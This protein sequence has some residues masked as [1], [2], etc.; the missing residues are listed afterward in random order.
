MVLKE[1]DRVEIQKENLI[2]KNE[3]PYVC[4]FCGTIIAGSYIDWI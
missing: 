1:V 3:F 4:A 2:A